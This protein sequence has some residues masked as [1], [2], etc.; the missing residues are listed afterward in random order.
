MVGSSCGSFR[1]VQDGR[2]KREKQ[3]IL[4][5][6]SPASRKKKP[7]P[8]WNLPFRRLSVLYKYIHESTKREIEEEEREKRGRKKVKG[9]LRSTGRHRLEAMPVAF[10]SLFPCRT[11][12]WARGL[13]NGTTAGQHREVVFF[14]KFYL[15]YFLITLGMISKVRNTA[16]CF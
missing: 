1:A 16:R 11:K 6:P 5:R 15:F 7:S 9:A 10:K 2:R 3:N 4:P 14:F 8:N 13:T 12:S